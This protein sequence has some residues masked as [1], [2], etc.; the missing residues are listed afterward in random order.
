L[1]ERTTLDEAALAGLPSR[2]QTVARNL[3]LTNPAAARA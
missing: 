1:S 3:A 2:V